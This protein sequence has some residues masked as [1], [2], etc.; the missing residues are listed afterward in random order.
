MVFDRKAKVSKSRIYKFKDKGICNNNVLHKSSSSV[1]PNHLMKKMATLTKERRSGWLNIKAKLKAKLE[2]NTEMVKK[3]SQYVNKLLG[4]CKSWSGPVCSEE[5]QSV[6]KKRQDAAE[7]II[8]V[9]LTYYK[10]ALIRVTH[11]ERLSN[12]MVLLNGQALGVCNFQ[13][14]QVSSKT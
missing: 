1:T 12:L 10:H 6:M 11:K 9:E 8:K 13:S 7:I 3:Q 5:L 14:G 4:Q 2:E